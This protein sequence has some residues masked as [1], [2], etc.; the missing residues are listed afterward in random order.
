MP[1]CRRVV[2]FFFVVF[3]SC[4]EVRIEELTGTYV[5][6]LQYVRHSNSLL[7]CLH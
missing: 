2:L 3:I 7:W 1:V 6:Y 4:D 5:S